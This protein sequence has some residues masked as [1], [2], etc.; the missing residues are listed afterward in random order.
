M[1]I[2]VFREV[3]SFVNHLKAGISS[4]IV[5]HPYGEKPLTSW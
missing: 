5:R 3:K 4:F 1:V 2:K